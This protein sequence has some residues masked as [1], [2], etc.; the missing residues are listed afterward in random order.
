MLLGDEAQKQS[1]L[2]DAI[3]HYKLAW[4][5][6][7]DITF[8]NKLSATYFEKLEYKR[9]IARAN[10]AIKEGR[11]MSAAPSKIAEF[12]PAKTKADERA[13]GRIGTNYLAMNDMDQAI[14][15]YQKSLREFINPDIV[16]A[17]RE[18]HSRFQES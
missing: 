4:K 12:F 18:V 7:K 2:D 8:L 5:L 3:K 1:K 14:N 9:S 10:E 13:Y 6:F 15:F 17:L 11:R 16:N